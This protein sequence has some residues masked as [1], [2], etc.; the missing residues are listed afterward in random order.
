MKHKHA[1]PLW[2]ALL[3]ASASLG[4]C[5]NESASSPSPPTPSPPTAPPAYPVMV[6][7]TN[8]LTFGPGGIAPAGTT[9]HI[10][11]VTK[12]DT[13]AFNLNRCG[14]PCTTAVTITIWQPE[15]YRVGDDLSWRA[16]SEGWYYMWAED[17]RT[18]A[19]AT[20]V[21]DQIRGS[22]LRITFDSGAVIDAWYTVP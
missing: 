6:E 14:E 10:S 5:G 21:S 1:P 3:V 20:A 7:P 15:V 17:L 12:S 8:R 9:F 19:P 2:I 22:K 11:V 4:G 16:V 13:T 18:N